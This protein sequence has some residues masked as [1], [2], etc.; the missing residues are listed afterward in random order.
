MFSTFFFFLSP[1]CFPLLSSR[2]SSPPS[3]E[4][5]PQEVL[6]AS[7]SKV[8]GIVH[9][10]VARRNSFASF[11]PLSTRL[12]PLRTRY[13]EISFVKK[14]IE[15][16]YIPRGERARLCVCEEIESKAAREY[17][18]FAVSRNVPLYTDKRRLELSRQGLFD[19]TR[20]SNKKEKKKKIA[21][22]CSI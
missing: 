12:L 8:S 6:Q 18:S 21:T 4:E 11:F 3:V 5:V 15:L 20:V 1:F 17:I 19:G 14:S 22:G 16:R 9:R 2:L 13:E 10:A 7:Y